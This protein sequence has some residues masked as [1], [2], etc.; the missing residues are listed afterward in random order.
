MEREGGGERTKRRHK[1]ESRD[2]VHSCICTFFLK[3][4]MIENFIIVMN[5]MMF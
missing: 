5:D 2:C 4:L 3:H 1:H